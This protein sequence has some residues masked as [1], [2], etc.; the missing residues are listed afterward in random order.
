GWTGCDTVRQD[1][2]WVTMNADHGVTATFVP[3]YAVTVSDA[4][5][6][7]IIGGEGHIYCGSSCSYRFPKGDQVEFTAIPAPGFTFTGWTGCDNVQGSYCFVTP[8]SARNVTATF[9][10][11][12][13]TLTSLVLKPSSVKGGQPSAATL[14]LSGAAP[15][16]GLGVSIASNVPGAAHPPAWIVVPGGKTTASFAVR[17]LPVKSNTMVNISAS[18]GGSQQSAT[19]TVTNGYGSNQ[20]VE[21]PGFSPTK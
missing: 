12:P 13:I 2:C 5:S 9:T 15:A 4:G 17:T 20:A 18:T 21:A 19:L 7:T 10:N 1:T 8:N 16:G 11:S 14:T 6:G 3:T